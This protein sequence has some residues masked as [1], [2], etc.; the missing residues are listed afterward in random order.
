MR[1]FRLG[2]LQICFPSCTQFLLPSAAMFELLLGLAWTCGG[3][4]LDPKLPAASGWAMRFADIWLLSFMRKKMGLTMGARQ[5]SASARGRRAP[6]WL[7]SRSVQF[8]AKIQE[9]NWCDHEFWFVWVFLLRNA[10][11]KGVACGDLEVLGRRALGVG[12][13][14]RCN[15]QRKIF[16]QFF[17]KLHWCNFWRKL[18]FVF[19]VITNF[20]F[21]FG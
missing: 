7:P 8:L 6:L 1:H 20:S 15:F 11:A 9:K 13:A 4:V 12:A 17:K 3:E 18:C 5:P 19:G 14:A 16:V 2:D 21:C 10:K